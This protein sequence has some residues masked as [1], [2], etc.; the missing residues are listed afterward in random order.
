MS[1]GHSEGPGTDPDD[2]KSPYGTGAGQVPG[3]GRLSHDRERSAQRRPSGHAGSGHAG[4]FGHGASPYDDQAPDGP[5]R[6]GSPY[7]GPAYGD[8]AYT[9]QDHD[10]PTLVGLD[11]GGEDHTLRG[12]DL[13]YSGRT[14][15]DQGHTGGHHDT[16]WYG[17]GGH[18]AAGH[19][20]GP[21]NGGHDGGGHPD[22][23]HAAGEYAGHTR[24]DHADPSLHGYGQSAPSPYGYGQGYVEQPH[25]PGHGP[26]TSRATEGVRT[27]A[28]VAMVVGIVLSLSFFLSIGGLVAVVLSGL[29]L[30]RV[31][32]DT[33]GAGKLLRRAW[34]G[35]GVNIGLIVLGAVVFVVAGLNHAF[36][37]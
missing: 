6:T 8:P 19:G 4:A 2:W 1:S 28:I 16:G 35:I 30:G 15:A 18:T 32:T 21:G 13:G 7:S 12:H 17:G 20:G 14:Y 31:D 34:I 23:G 33:R 29:A 11:L 36:G 24:R 3:D 22:A 9:D 10:A 25:A 26:G 27:H 37:P 5:A